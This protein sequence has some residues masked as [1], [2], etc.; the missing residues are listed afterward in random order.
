M[1]EERLTVIVPCL[2]EAKS[3]ERTVVEIEGV[4]PDLDIDLDIILIDDGSLDNTYEV[5]LE[6]QEKFD[7]VSVYRNE[8][9]LGVGRSIL[10]T[11]RELPDDRWVTVFPGDG[12]LV[13]HSIKNHLAVRHEYDL[14]L[15][16]LHNGVIR[17]IHRRLA[18]QAFTQT[19]NFL[20]GYPFR[21]LNGMKL[22]RA[23][24]FKGID[25]ESNG[26][27]FN[28]ELLGKALLRDPGLRVAEVP[29]RARGRSSGR[30]KAIQPRSVVEAVWD[31][32]RG[33]AAVSRFREEIIA[34]LRIDQ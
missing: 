27:A 17:P 15:G 26:H 23:S 10:N 11:Y 19:V 2:N 14:I 25:V 6:I 31:V 13:F 16:Y 21:Y 30:S 18:S 9:N 33:Y 5:M 1:I 8:M 29:F 20:Y 3:L 34:T 32:Y 7:G 12:E 28:A 22:Y 4:R 24:V